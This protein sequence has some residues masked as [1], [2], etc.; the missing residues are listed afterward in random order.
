M[1]D[2]VAHRSRENRRI[3]GRW[4][5]IFRQQPGPNMN[6]L[7]ASECPE[8][9]KRQDTPVSFLDKTRPSPAMLSLPRE[10][11]GNTKGKEVFA[12]FALFCG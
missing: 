2:K 3:A 6:R 12:L 11:A 1:G 7:F 9:G 10:N 8:T 5:A 4:P